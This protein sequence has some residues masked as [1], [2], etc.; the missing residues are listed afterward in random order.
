MRLH[1]VAL[2]LQI[3]GYCEYQKNP[4]FPF[5]P[6][7]APASFLQKKIKLVK[8]SLKVDCNSKTCY[9]EE[10]F[11]GLKNGMCR[12]QT[13]NI[14]ISDFQRIKDNSEK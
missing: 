14:F 7:P 9:T 13:Q 10:H 5:G 3:L 8:S 2:F 1:Q 11:F 12:I 6:F 4:R